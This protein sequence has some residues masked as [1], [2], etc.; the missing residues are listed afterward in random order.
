[1]SRD[2]QW[3]TISHALRTSWPWPAEQGE[4]DDLARH[5]RTW[6]D[7]GPVVAAVEY[8][9]RSTPDR[10]PSVT[11]LAAEADRRRRAQTS[12][13]EP[14][15]CPTCDSDGWLTVGFSD[16][17]R[18]LPELRPC[19]TC[20]P[21]TAQ[22]HAAGHY[23]MDAPLHSIA[24][25]SPAAEAARDSNAAAPRYGPRRRGP[26]ISRTDFERRNTP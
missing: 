25:R 20:R 24:N 1:M 6:T 12:P 21:G 14:V 13:G 8:F 26:D 7:L 11:Q 19:P 16:D 15:P 18:R 17:A 5:V 9:Q 2:G 22:M 4:L 10:R 3:G 23:R